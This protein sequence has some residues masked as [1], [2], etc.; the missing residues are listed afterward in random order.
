[1]LSNPILGG[2]NVLKSLKALARMTVDDNTPPR[3]R[4]DIEE[5]KHFEDMLIKMSNR[6]STTIDSQWQ[7]WYRFHP[8]LL[9]TAEFIVENMRF[10]YAEDKHHNI[11]IAGAVPENL[12]WRGLRGIEALDAMENEFR[13]KTLLGLWLLKLMK[14]IWLLMETAGEDNGVKREDRINAIRAIVQRERDADKIKKSNGINGF[15]EKIT[16]QKI[17]NNIEELLNT[18]PDEPLDVV[19][20]HLSQRLKEDTRPLPK[21][22]GLLNPRTKEEW[23]I[24]PFGTPELGG[25]AVAEGGDKERQLRR[26]E[27]GVNTVISLSS[28]TKDSQRLGQIR[29]LDKEGNLLLLS[30]DAIGRFGFDPEPETV[31]VARTENEKTKGMSLESVTRRKL[32][33]EKSIEVRGVE[34]IVDDYDKLLSGFRERWY[35][36][37]LNDLWY[38]LA[39][40]LFE[41]EKRLT[42]ERLKEWAGRLKKGCLELKAMWE[43]F[44]KPITPSDYEKILSKVNDISETCDELMSVGLSENE[45]NAVIQDIRNLS[46]VFSIFK[47][48]GMLN[49]AEQDVISSSIKFAI[50]RAEQYARINKIVYH[51]VHNRFILDWEA[52]IEPSDEPRKIALDSRKDGF[53]DNISFMLI[54][55]AATS[56]V[57]F[58]IAPLFL[59]AGLTISL[60]DSW[61]VF[62]I[63]ALGTALLSREDEEGGEKAQDRWYRVLPDFSGSQPIRAGSNNKTVINISRGLSDYQSFLAQMSMVEVF[64]QVMSGGLVYIDAG[65]GIGRAAVEA[66]WINPHLKSY[67]IDINR[68]DRKDSSLDEEEWR[69]FSEKRNTLEKEGRYKFING[70]VCDPAVFRPL[71]KADLITSF[72]TLQYADD[73]IRAIANFY[74]QLKTGGALIATIMVPKTGD[75]LSHY[76]NIIEKLNRSGMAVS[77]LTPFTNVAS[78]D[79]SM[80]LITVR[81]LRDDE[82]VPSSA[83]AGTDRRE[84]TINGERFVVSI[85]IYKT[86]DYG[87]IARGDPKAL[88]EALITSPQQK[89]PSAS[90]RTQFSERI[91]GILKRIESSNLPLSLR[92]ELSNRIKEAGDMDVVK[93]RAVVLSGPAYREGGKG[94]LLGFNTMP[95][96]PDKVVNDACLNNLQQLLRERYPRTIGLAIEVLNVLEKSDSCLEEYLFH[97]II[98]PHVGHE[99]ARMIQEAIFAENYPSYLRNEKRPGHFDGLLSSKLKQVIEEIGEEGVESEEETEVLAE[100]GDSLEDDAEEKE[101]SQDELLAEIDNALQ[102]AEA[103]IDDAERAKDPQRIRWAIR[104]DVRPV[105]IAIR[106]MI[107]KIDDDKMREFYHEQY[108]DVAKDAAGAFWEATENFVNENLEKAHSMGERLVLVRKLLRLSEKD[109]SDRLGLDENIWRAYEDGKNEDVPQHILRRIEGLAALPAG[110]L[111]KSDTE[112]ERPNKFWGPGTPH[113]TQPPDEELGRPSVTFEEKVSAESI[114]KDYFETLFEANLRLLVLLAKRMKAKRHSDKD[115][116]VSAKIETLNYVDGLL[117]EIKV[118]EERLKAL[119]SDIR[120]AEYHRRVKEEFDKALAMISKDNEP[121]ANAALV[122]AMNAVSGAREEI[123]KKRIISGQHKV[124]FYEKDGKIVIQ[125]HSYIRAGEEAKTLVPIYI[126]KKFDLRWQV[127]R[128]LDDQIESLL[129]ERDVL[130]GYIDM[131]TKEIAV[132]ASDASAVNTGNISHILYGLAGVIVEEKRLARITLETAID[133]IDLEDTASLKHLLPIAKRYLGLRV[134]NID[135]MLHYLKTGRVEPYRDMVAL[136]NKELVSRMNKINI[137]LDKGDYRSARNNAYG[138]YR[139]IK[140]QLNEPD[141]EGLD[142]ILWPLIRETE[143]VLNASAEKEKSVHISRAKFWAGILKDKIGEAALLA[144]FM[145][146]FRDKYETERLAGGN[147]RY[148]KEDTFIETFES[149]IK[150]KQLIRGSPR[151]TS[152]KML[153]Y[154]AAFVSMEKSAFKAIS[155]LRLIAAVDDI[156]RVLR[157]NRLKDLSATM[158]VLNKYSNRE[159]IRRLDKIARTELVR[160]LASDFGLDEAGRFEVAKAFAINRANLHRCFEEEALYVAFRRFAKICRDK[161]NLIRAYIERGDISG[162]HSHAV[163]IIAS[164]NEEFDGIAT[165]EFIDLVRDSMTG[166]IAIIYHTDSASVDKKEMLK[167]LEGSE[168]SLNELEKL[169]EAGRLLDAVGAWVK[170]GYLDSSLVIGK[171]MPVRNP[172]WGPGTPHITQPPDKDGSA[173]IMEYAIRRAQEEC[174]SWDVR[175]IENA[176]VDKDLGDKHDSEKHGIFLWT[177]ASIALQII[178]YIKLINPSANICDLGSGNGMFCFLASKHFKD[179]SGIEWNENL[180]RAA[181]SHQK[182]LGLVKRARNVR[183]I[184][185]DFLAEDTDLSGYDVLYFFYTCP[186]GVDSAKWHDALRKKMVSKN[187]MRDGAKL[188]IFGDLDRISDEGLLY[189]RVPLKSGYL[190]VYTRKGS[191]VGAKEPIILDGTAKRLPD[192]QQNSIAVK[193]SSF[194]EPI[195]IRCLIRSLE[196]YFTNALEGARIAQIMLADNVWTPEKAALAESSLM[197]IQKFINMLLADR[198]EVALDGKGNPDCIYLGDEGGVGAHGK[199]AVP[200]QE[201]SSL[202]DNLLLKE[203]FEKERL[204]AEEQRRLITQYD[205]EKRDDIIRN[206]EALIN[207]YRAIREKL[208]AGKSNQQ[209]TQKSLSESPLSSVVETADIKAAIEEIA[210]ISGDNFFTENMKKHILK[211]VANMGLKKGERVLVVGPGNLD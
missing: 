55:G 95:R 49:V 208:V 67:G 63:A 200:P 107:Y 210:R 199:L 71:E 102:V 204:L 97:E 138:L 209:L 125:Q 133:L 99:K 136:H 196:H 126:D 165:D 28:F 177:P 187:G 45:L 6:H 17:L 121:A 137:L 81:K 34:E 53:S 122:G 2:P 180:H 10:V 147:R 159:Y 164:I 108:L 65:C 118:F 194:P 129:D 152:F 144:E 22:F 207:G 202:K 26:I 31:L 178:H 96:A 153:C 51:K 60:L 105:L 206:S 44:P 185:G 46:T 195:L 100:S 166:L 128:S 30:V 146:S 86:A 11:Y 92:K 73:P 88:Y 112:K 193:E 42:I 155:T 87:Q 151:A 29:I 182:D 68:W 78:D 175:L 197:R 77:S 179:V 172:G 82:L 162:A 12:K 135:S 104:D 142:S 184:K 13:Q 25:I 7:L 119:P 150:A 40:P 90:F 106:L 91:K 174:Y 33:G 19:F 130:S 56:T 94:W 145:E 161:I 191:V 47:D 101:I 83:L 20:E 157:M 111:S 21:I 171:S 9:D 117:K 23:A 168:K 103:R 173:L 58:I 4:K 123:L 52:S 110:T 24:T 72:F 43:A 120:M 79:I 211:K 93:F 186:A 170:S 143:G 38:L 48:R 39:S 139:R 89:L 201:W 59:K 74:N 15:G 37:I 5:A 85:P 114:Y 154:L 203:L 176:C 167:C 54:L 70:D 69:S 190:N 134:E 66:S 149:F 131:V 198:V 156:K 35:T 115:A 98:C 1:W 183:F 188:I 32:Y 140:S 160:A 109:I 61:S 148:L 8:K 62:A 75:L 14:E 189:E 113:I 57:A 64:S 50:S 205:G 3:L 181:L 36:K 27:L 127:G 132:T 16:K 124:R 169:C 84:V 76:H 41:K 192:A 163:N 141:L 116:L 158:A 18:G 80:Y